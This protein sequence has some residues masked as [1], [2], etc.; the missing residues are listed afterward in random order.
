MVLNASLA[1]SSSAFAIYGYRLVFL[2]QF[3]NG[4]GKVLV[5][6]IDV[7][8]ARNMSFRIFGNSAYIYQLD[9]IVFYQLFEMGC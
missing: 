9:F 1:A 7:Q 2:Q 6:N 8:A 5:H 4:C 3:I